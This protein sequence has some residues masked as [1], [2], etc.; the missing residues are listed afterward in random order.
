MTGLDVL[1]GA[2]RDVPIPSRGEVKVDW[3]VRARQVRS[4][5]VTAKAITDV[6][7]DA[8]EM[9]LPVNVPGVKMAQAR[10][11]ALNGGAS[12]A[13]DLTFPPN[14]QPGSRLLSIRLSPSIVGSLFAALDYLTSFPYGCVEQ[15]M[16]SFLP[17]IIVQQAVRDLKLKTNLDQPALQEKIRAGLDRLY[18]LQHED[19]GWGWWETD[20]SQPFMT[21]YVVAGLAQ[22]RAAGT[23]VKPEAIANGV[24]WLKKGF[25]ADPRLVADLRAYMMYALA[26]AGEADGAGLSQVYA[27]R[28][29]FRRMAWRFW[30]W[31]LNKPK[32]RAPASWPPPSKPA[33][34]PTRSRP[35]GAPRATNCWISPATH[36][37]S[38]SLRRQVPL[39][40]APRERAAAEGGAV[41]DESPQRGL[42]VVVHQ[43]NRHGD[44][45][46]KRLLNRY[47]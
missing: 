8:L 45:R 44:L 47:P 22:A 16:S 33:C 15:T 6:E 10:G 20:E 38:H 17:N 43:A 30:D 46:I 19:G 1:E 28:R 12:A 21:A 42:L 24:E 34:K 11:G 40:S 37:R 41:A 13:F 31:R 27:R 7:S 5:Q 35:G 3:R 39:A 36:A 26:A 2:T 4:A 14:A 18:A 25:A 32:T 29:A 23:E 9:D